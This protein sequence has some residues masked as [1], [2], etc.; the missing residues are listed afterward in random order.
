MDPDWAKKAGVDLK[1]PLTKH[2]EVEDRDGPSAADEADRMVVEAFK[3]GAG[4]GRDLLK[5]VEN[6]EALV[7]SVLA[8]RPTAAKRTYILKASLSSTMGPGIPLAIR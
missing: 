4:E 6:A 3:M 7:D 1:L 5:I 8:A 2:V